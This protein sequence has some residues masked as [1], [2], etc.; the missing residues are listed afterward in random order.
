[1]RASLSRELGWALMAIGSDPRCHP[2]L[3]ARNDYDGETDSL[4]E[5]D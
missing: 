3:E 1:M 4:E 2:V 5:D